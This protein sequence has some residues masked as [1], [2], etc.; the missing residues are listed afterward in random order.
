MSNYTTTFTTTDLHR[1][2]ITR[3]NIEIQS[4]KSRERSNTKMGWAV[5][6]RLCRPPF[7]QFFTELSLSVKS[8]ARGHS[9]TRV[10][11]RTHSWFIQVTLRARESRESRDAT[12][13]WQAQSRESRDLSAVARSSAKETPSRADF[14]LNWIGFDTIRMDIYMYMMYKS[15]NF[16]YQ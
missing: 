9:T 11:A 2:E 14:F 4:E 12:S 3:A 6:I 5:E 1:Y 10:V 7:C 8:C 16:I 13:S 15:L